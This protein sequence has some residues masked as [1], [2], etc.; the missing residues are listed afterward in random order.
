MDTETRAFI[1]LRIMME[2]GC[3]KPRCEA[4]YGRN[5]KFVTYTPGVREDLNQVFS[6]MDIFEDCR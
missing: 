1:A 3:Y 4:Y 5:K 2:Y 6:F